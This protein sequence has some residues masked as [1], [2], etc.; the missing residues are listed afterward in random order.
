M[1]YAF[2]ELFSCQISGNSNERFLRKQFI[3]T[4]TTSRNFLVKCACVVLCGFHGKDEKHA[5][6]LGECFFCSER[7]QKESRNEKLSYLGS[8]L[9]FIIHFMWNWGI[10]LSTAVFAYHNPSAR[11]IAS[12]T[13]SVK[14]AQTVFSHLK[15]IFENYTTN[16]FFFF[17]FNFPR[18][19]LVRNTFKVAEN[20]LHTYQ[21]TLRKVEE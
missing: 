11:L 19:A 6:G 9:N 10:T 1:C 3:S 2:K 4:K 7:K 18:N 16:F 14:R 12:L 15:R 13:E 21:A 5:K 17:F 8:K 20:M